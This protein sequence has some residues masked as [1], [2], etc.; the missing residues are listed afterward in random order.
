[1]LLTRLITTL[2]VCLAAAST[3]VAQVDENL[4]PLTEP[5]SRLDYAQ[6]WWEYGSYERVIEIVTPM[7]SEDIVEGLE[8]EEAIDAY[9]L[10]GSS[11]FLLDRRSE[12]HSPFYHLLVIEPDYRLDP[13]LYPADMVDELERIKAFY[14]EELN[15]IREQR[16]GNGGSSELIYVERRVEERS[17]VVSML[18]FGVGHFV[19]DQ[20]EWGAT[21]ATVEATLAALSVGY[22]LR[23]E[24]SRDENGFYPDVSAS[25]Q[26]QRVQIGTG[27]AFFVVVA[28]NMVHGAVIHEPVVE[29]PFEVI[30]DPVFEEPEARRWQPFVSGSPE[31]VLFG[32]GGSW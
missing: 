1:V 20:P 9:V 17:L 19:N 32:L 12:A 11:Y 29:S 23:N 8:R 30:E 31:G 10:L 22:F 16:R 4:P 5:R 18:P 6:N 26:R 7:V 14:E 3:A 13:F 21:Y 28:I 24:A 25:E 15:E 27:V 2:L